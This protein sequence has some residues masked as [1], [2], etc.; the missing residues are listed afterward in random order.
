[1]DQTPRR[2]LQAL[3]WA[4]VLGVVALL[5][6]LTTVAQHSGVDSTRLA[7]RLSISRVANAGVVWAGISVLAGWIVRRHWQACLAGLAAG[8]LALATHY[9]LGRLLAAPTSVVEGNEMWFLAA[10]LCGAPLG[11]VG[12]L[13]HHRGLLG[14][15]AGCV[16]PVGAVAEPFVRGS[17]TMHAILP[18]PD[19]V[20]SVASGVVLLVG[21]LLML[22][23]TWRWQS[24]HRRVPDA[25]PT[26]NNPEKTMV[27][28]M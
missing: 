24:G 10:A 5:T 13:V 4:V 27:E 14:R 7:V 26:G 16:V 15:L 9:G 11:L 23:P 6:N 8:E 19:R 20:S 1:M 21:G 3:G 18:W 17:F 12:A 28:S 25:A 22:V 2:W